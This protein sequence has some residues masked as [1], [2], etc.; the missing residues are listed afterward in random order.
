MPAVGRSGMNQ[1]LTCPHGRSLFLAMLLV[2]APLGAF[3]VPVAAGRR[4]PAITM[5]AED[6]KMVVDMEVAKHW[7][8]TAE[9]GA[10]LEP[11]V[12]TKDFSKPMSIPEEG[13]RNAVE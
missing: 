8:I 12:F 1:R 6:I 7:D 4:A 11:S 9:P 2:A 3:K 13:I 10:M 5:S